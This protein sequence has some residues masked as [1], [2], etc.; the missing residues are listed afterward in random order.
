[1]R[2]ITLTVYRSNSSD[3]LV[4]KHVISISSG[5]PWTIKEELT[6]GYCDLKPYN[7]LSERNVFFRMATK[8]ERCLYS[9]NYE[10]SYLSTALCLTF[11]M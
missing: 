9:I 6:K 3:S 2:P 4:D 1:M 8:V 11:L 10:V 7:P 5:L